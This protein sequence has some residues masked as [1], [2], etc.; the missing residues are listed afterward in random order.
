MS[1]YDYA[2]MFNKGTLNS[3]FIFLALG[4]VGGLPIAL[5]GIS[6]HEIGMIWG[7]FALVIF[8]S[9]CTILV[10]LGYVSSDKKAQQ[11]LIIDAGYGNKSLSEQ[12]DF[13]E[14]VC[15]YYRIEDYFYNTPPSR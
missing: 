6:C 4:L 3:A 8:F 5:N 1:K 2:F 12:I 14:R 7:F 9:L 10:Q 15:P 11:E 13:L